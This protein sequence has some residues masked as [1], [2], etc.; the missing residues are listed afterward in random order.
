MKTPR[1]LAAS[2]FRCDQRTLVAPGKVHFGSP[3][4]DLQAEQQLA[5]YLSYSLIFRGSN[6]QGNEQL[7]F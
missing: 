2:V 1:V 6:A 3:C 7:S 4:A 5:L